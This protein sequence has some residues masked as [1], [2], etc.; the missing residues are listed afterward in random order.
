MQKLKSILLLIILGITILPWQM[1]CAEHPFGEHHQE[2]DGPSPCELRRI[3]LQKPGEH[4]LPPMECENITSLVAD[5]NSTE[6]NKI[7]PTVQIVA[8]LAVVFDLVVFEHQEQP[9]LTPPDPNC[10]SATL[11]SDSPLRAPPL[12]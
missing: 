5:Y 6:V 10:R 12:V 9:F 2:H 3:A 4:L 1:V 11:L 7:V 8:I